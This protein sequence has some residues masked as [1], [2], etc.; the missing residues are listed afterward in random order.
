MLCFHRAYKEHILRCCFITFTVFPTFNIVFGWPSL[1]SPHYF[2][3]HALFYLASLSPRSIRS[4][5]VSY[6]ALIKL[7]LQNEL[8][9]FSLSCQ[10]PRSVKSKQAANGTADCHCRNVCILWEEEDFIWA[11]F[12]E[13]DQTSLFYVLILLRPRKIWVALNTRWGKFFFG[14][15]SE[16]SLT[17]TVSMSPTSFFFSHMYL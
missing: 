14:V 3:I 15:V 13:Y 16:L 11:I 6:S 7:W 2:G 8:N 9:L 12:I 1:T 10:I 4:T 17:V 5:V